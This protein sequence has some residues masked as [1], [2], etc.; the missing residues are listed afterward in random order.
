MCIMTGA[1]NAGR[2]RNP[3]VI[4]NNN[5][6]IAGYED[7]ALEGEV[8][9]LTCLPGQMLNGTDTSTCMRYGEWEPDPGEVNCI[10]LPTSMTTSHGGTATLSKYI[11]KFL[12]YYVYL[13]VCSNI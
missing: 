8:I 10:S 4:V 7:P 1:C 6:R 5:V 11:T 2:C 3:M 9:T 13:V 12:H